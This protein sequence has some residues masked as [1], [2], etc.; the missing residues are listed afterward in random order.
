M[1]AKL[2]DKVDSVYYW[3]GMVLFVVAV[4]VAMVS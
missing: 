3:G 4:V 2:R 1:N